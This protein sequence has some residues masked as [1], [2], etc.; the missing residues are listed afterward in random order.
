MSA[1]HEWIESGGGP[2]LFAPQSVLVDWHGNRLPKD[3]V[4]LTDYARACAIKDEIGVIAIGASQ[5]LVLGDEPDRTS[6]IVYSSFDLMICRWRWADSE[7]SLLGAL[8]SA[9]VRQLPFTS[10]GR[11]DALPDQ[12][13]LFDSA[14]SGNK[15]P[16][17]LSAK[18]GARPYLFD[19]IDFRPS[20][21]I[22]ALIHRIRAVTS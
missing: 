13:H 1:A 21:N 12:Y 22:Y 18:L 5:G 20:K 2:L 9:G 14:Y 15:V 4:G 6:L 19:S 16:R 10:K 11:F 17:S 8:D 7:A 3:R